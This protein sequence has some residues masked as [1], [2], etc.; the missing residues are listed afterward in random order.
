M[1]RLARI[2][3]TIDAISRWSGYV[4]MFLVVA[5]GLLMSTEVVARYVFNAPTLWATESTAL[6]FGIY[7]MLAGAY[8]LLIHGHVTMDAVYSRLSLRR[9]AI[10]DLLTSF[11]FFFFCGVL[12]WKGI[13]TAIKSVAMMEHSMSA[14]GA[15]YWPIKIAIPLGAFLILLQGLAKFTRDFHI[16]LTGRKLA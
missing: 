1:L 3:S 7:M 10:L 6:V 13:P 2:V 8:T 9:K 4:A 15:P 5:L 12:L 14:W 11:L 16:A